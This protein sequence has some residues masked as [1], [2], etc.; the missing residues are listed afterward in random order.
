VS[1][2]F[3]WP[4][5]NR[6]IAEPKRGGDDW[7]CAKHAVLPNPNI[8]PQAGPILMKGLLKSMQDKLMHLIYLNNQKFRITEKAR[9][10]GQQ[11]QDK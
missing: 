2:L 3:A 7:A 1:A 4:P 5:T 8:H 6:Q 11:G 9:D 10:F